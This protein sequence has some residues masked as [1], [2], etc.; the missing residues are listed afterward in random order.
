MAGAGLGG[1]FASDP[2]P[3]PFMAIVPP[4]GAVLDDNGQV[5][6]DPEPDFTQPTFVDNEGYDPPSGNGL[7]HPKY[8]VEQ[9]D[10]QPGLIVSD[11]KRRFSGGSKLDQL[12][13]VEENIRDLL[14]ERRRLLGALK[15]ERDEINERL[16]VSEDVTKALDEMF[17]EK[18]EPPEFAPESEDE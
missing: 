13:L 12:K 1:Y 5:H 14:I 6:V 17:P 4:T 7:L 15:T 8:P 2:N 3:N 11:F 16:N 9:W 18:E 10:N